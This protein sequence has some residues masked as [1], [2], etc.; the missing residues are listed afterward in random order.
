MTDR[1]EDPNE[2]AFR[3]VREATKRDPQEPAP[4]EPKKCGKRVMLGAEVTRCFLERDHM[5][6]CKGA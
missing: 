3:V 6:P 2:A 1:D 4:Q 5:G